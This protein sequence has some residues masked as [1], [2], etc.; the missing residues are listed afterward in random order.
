[1]S[2][3]YARESI[4][5]VGMD[6]HK[7]S[8]EIA[9]ADRRTAAGCNPAEESRRRI[10]GAFKGTFVRTIERLAVQLGKPHRVP[11]PTSA[12]WSLKKASRSDPQIGPFFQIRGPS[13]TS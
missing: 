9:A 12:G 2:S 11:S 10:K 13:E 1:M 8:I 3:G 6:Q 5:Y 7:E 4:M